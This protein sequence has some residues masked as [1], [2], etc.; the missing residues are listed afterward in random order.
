MSLEREKQ[1]HNWHMVLTK[2]TPRHVEVRPPKCIVYI[3]QNPVTFVIQRYHELFLL[4]QQARERKHSKAYKR[5]VHRLPTQPATTS[6]PKNT[7]HSGCHQTTTICHRSRCFSREHRD[8]SKLQHP[9]QQCPTGLS[10][11]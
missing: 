8:T 7:A 9:Q 1:Q 10:L 4:D 5:H 3:T 2:A 11:H 6:T